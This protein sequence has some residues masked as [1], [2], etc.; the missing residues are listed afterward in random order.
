MEYRIAACDIG[1]D[2]VSFAVAAVTPDGVIRF[3]DIHTVTH[4]GKV[5]DTFQN[6][7]ET[8][9]IRTCRFLAATGLYAEKLA[10]PVMIFPE[11]TCREAWL[12]D[13]SGRQGDF[14]DTRIYPGTGRCHGPGKAKPKSSKSP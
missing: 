13:P 8:R 7:Y 3:E 9:E 2:T 14:P 10:G 1:K 4:H 12:E 6:W 5:T 11:D